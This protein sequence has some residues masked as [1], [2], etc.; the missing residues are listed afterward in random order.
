LLIALPEHTGHTGDQDQRSASRGRAR[1][2][3]F[4][5][6]PSAKLR[7]IDGGSGCEIKRAR[8]VLHS[9]VINQAEFERLKRQCAGLSIPSDVPP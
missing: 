3:H 6:P 7:T 5:A 1:R 8:H 9:R 2:F 4:V